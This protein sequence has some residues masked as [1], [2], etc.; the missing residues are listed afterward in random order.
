[1]ACRKK[2]KIGLRNKFVSLFVL[3]LLIPVISICTCGLLIGN[4]KQNVEQSSMDELQNIDDVVC[5]RVR[6]IRH[7][8]DLIKVSDEVQEALVSEGETI[9][10]FESVMEKY[11]GNTNEIES[12]IFVTENGK[13]LTYTSK[14]MNIDYIKLQVLYNIRDENQH[15]LT[16]FAGKEKNAEIGFDED[17]VVVG[18]VC[19]CGIDTNTYKQT[20]K[21]YVC[22]A[23]EVFSDVLNNASDGEKLFVLDKDGILLSADAKRFWTDKIESSVSLMDRLYQSD[24]GIV[25]QDDDSGKFVLSHYTSY[26][27]EFKYVKKC[28]LHVFYKGVYKIIYIL[29]LITALIS[30]IILLIYI[31]LGKTIIA[32]LRNLAG[33][34]E[35]FDNE[36]LY[37][38]MPVTSNDEIGNVIRGFNKMRERICRIISEAKIEERE[39]KDIEFEALHH[40]INPH[41][42]YN[43]L[44]AIRITAMQNHDNDIADALL[45]LNKILKSVFSKAN[46]Y[47]TCKEEVEMLQDYVKLL[48]LRFTNKI[49]ID[50]NV[51]EEVAS[52]MVPTMLLQPI[53]ENSIFHGLSKKM[54]E[55][56]F[57]A[58][59]LI[60]F[61]MQGDDLLIEVFDNGEGMSHKTIENILFGDSKDGRGI[62]LSNVDK[63][64]K[65]LYGSEYGISIDSELN[66]Y[67]NV[68]IKLKKI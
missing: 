58:R 44:G 20:A 14:P 10:Q 3:I 63:R 45:L 35:N 60:N 18:T 46:K 1:M 34:M 11:V 5:E 2:I 43:T 59:I 62:G 54:S 38:E 21:M 28:D 25:Q 13:I 49:H 50:A 64:I 57:V 23:K 32:P 65:L 22:V 47:S 67:T 37:H 61:E 6:D 33:E 39:K 53:V 16:W 52:V 36:A 48:E 51:P 56:N 68:S 4:I 31:L 26:T 9:T 17:I 24:K 66:V 15:T 42:I 7:S 41:F 27:G 30:S 19:K 55:V 29:S 12:V 8:I 40:Q